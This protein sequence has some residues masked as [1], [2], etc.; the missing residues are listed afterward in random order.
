M[1]AKRLCVMRAHAQQLGFIALF[2]YCFAN[3]VGR[4]CMHQGGVKISTLG[5]LLSFI[6]LVCLLLL[7]ILTAKGRAARVVEDHNQWILY[8]TLQLTKAI[9]I[10]LLYII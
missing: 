6:I 10:N 4:Q 9:F 8:A 3:W 2:L 1:Q 7:F 5:T